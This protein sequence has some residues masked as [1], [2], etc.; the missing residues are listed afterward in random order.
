MISQALRTLA[1]V[2]S[3]GVPA[4]GPP[5]QG[6]GQAAHGHVRATVVAGGRL[7]SLSVDPRVMRGGSEAMC[8]EIVTAVNAAVD[9][10]RAQAAE[11]ASD[12]AASS[13][14]I[15]ATL[16]GLQQESVRQMERFT[17]SL[18]DVVARFERRS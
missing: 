15:S 14:E 11:R 13:E 12:A 1:A 9:D 17:Q 10:L 4:E 6:E 2:R 5:L 18:N 16:L 8:A 3:S 7:A